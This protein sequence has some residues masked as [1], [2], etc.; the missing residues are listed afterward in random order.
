VQWVS[1]APQLMEEVLHL[2]GQRALPVHGQ[3]VVVVVQHN[4]AEAFQ[5]PLTC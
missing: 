4:A 3:R 5:P 2:L 1:L